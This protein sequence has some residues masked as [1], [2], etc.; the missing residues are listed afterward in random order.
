MRSNRPRSCPVRLA[1]DSRIDA[2][3]EA[4]HLLDG[5]HGDQLDAVLIDEGVDL[6]AGDKPSFSRISFGIT[7]WNLGEM[8]TVPMRPPSIELS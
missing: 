7:T 3:E 4:P 8:V 5:P 1:V 6:L 2:F